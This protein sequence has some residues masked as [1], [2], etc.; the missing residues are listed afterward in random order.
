MKMAAIPTITRNLRGIAKDKVIPL[1]TNLVTD[2]Y[3]DRV[4]LHEMAAI[5]L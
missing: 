1:V 3:L 2:Q 5:P 4:C